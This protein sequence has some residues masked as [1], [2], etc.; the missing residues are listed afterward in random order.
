[1]HIDNGTMILLKQAQHLEEV[2]TPERLTDRE[3]SRAIRDAIMAEEGAIKQYE[4]IVDAA[5]DEKIREVL[6]DIANEERV[7]VGELQ[8][9]L[10]GMLPDEEKFLEE[11]AKE[12][13]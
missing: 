4:A 3:L 2:K 13:E 12:V 9:L 6:Q 1:M 7:H 10:N 8:A 11:G 5:S